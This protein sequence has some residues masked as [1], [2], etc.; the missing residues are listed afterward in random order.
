MIIYFTY[1]CAIDRARILCHNYFLRSFALYIPL[2]DQ[3]SSQNIHSS[4]KKR[5]SLPFNISR[6]EKS[7]YLMLIVYSYL[8]FCP[9]LNKNES[10][11]KLTVTMSSLVA[12]NFLLILSFMYFMCSKLLL[13]IKS[14]EILIKIYFDPNLVWIGNLIKSCI[15]ISCGVIFSLNVC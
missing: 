13:C 15:K 11:L 2:L 3:N 5:S 12:L 14:T 8:E 4:V 10:S 7:K 9:E 6:K 1:L